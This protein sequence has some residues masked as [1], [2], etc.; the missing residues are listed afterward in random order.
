MYSLA[1]PAGRDIG[2]DGTP[3]VPLAPAARHKLYT[4]QFGRL[5][6]TPQFAGRFGKSAKILDFIQANRPAFNHEEDYLAMGGYYSSAGPCLYF[7]RVGECEKARKHLSEFSDGAI[8]GLASV[9]KEFIEYC[10]AR[11]NFTY[12]LYCLKNGTNDFSA[13]FS[14]AMVL[15]NLSNKYENEL[16]TNALAARDVESLQRYETVLNTICTRQSSKELKSAL[17]WIMSLRVKMLLAA[18]QINLKV[19]ELV[20]KNALKLNPENKLAREGLENIE[21]ELELETLDKALVNYKMNKACQIAAAAKS[22]EAKNMFFSC[23][24]N[25]FEEMENEKNTMIIP[26]Y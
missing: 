19:A 25:T 7:I 23:I 26:S 9:E 24:K 2:K 12:T 11:T 18:D 22:S 17:S 3:S 14:R 10:A 13:K 16:I 5:V 6:C 15:F 20:M 8:Y 4:G 1:V 21:I